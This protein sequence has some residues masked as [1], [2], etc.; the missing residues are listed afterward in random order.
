MIIKHGLT[1]WILLSWKCLLLQKKKARVGRIFRVTISMS[2]TTSQKPFS[3]GKDEHTILNKIFLRLGILLVFEPETVSCKL[4]TNIYLYY[5][6]DS[7]IHV[8]FFLVPHFTPAV[9]ESWDWHPVRSTVA[10]R[11]WGI[12]LNSYTTFLQP[13]NLPSTWGNTG[14]V[15]GRDFKMTGDK[16]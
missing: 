11:A 8:S 1:Y 7:A 16:D 13:T 5:Y 6:V 9:T 10:G 15:P 14:R 4:L 2:E 3:F 12:L